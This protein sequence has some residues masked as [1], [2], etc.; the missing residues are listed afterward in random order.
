[1][2]MGLWFIAAS[3]YYGVVLIST[4]MLNSSHNVCSSNTELNVSSNANQYE[5]ECSLHKCRYDAI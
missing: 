1:M 4:E 3:L 5:E 2:L